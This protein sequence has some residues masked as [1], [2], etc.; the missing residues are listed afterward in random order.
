MNGL[1]YDIVGARSKKLESDFESGCIIQRNGR[2]LGARL[3]GPRQGLAALEVAQHEGLH[4]RKVRAA[5]G[6]KPVVEIQW[7]EGRSRYPLTAETG[8]IGVSDLGSVVDQ[9]NHV[10][11]LLSISQIDRSHSG[12]SLFGWK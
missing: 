8:A 9:D 7:R 11:R 12:V 6:M 5:G 2:S 1:A 3:D 10:G 4:C